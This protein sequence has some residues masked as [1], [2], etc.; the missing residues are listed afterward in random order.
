ML[1]DLV[2]YAIDTYGLLYT[3]VLSIWISLFLIFI[4]LYF[5]TRRFEKECKIGKAEVVGIDTYETD[6]GLRHKLIVEL[7]DIGDGVH[8]S[9]QLPYYSKEN[10]V[11]KIIEVAYV[12]NLSGYSIYDSR[13]KGKGSL[14]FVFFFQLI[15]FIALVVLN[16]CP[17]LF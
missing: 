4:Y 14:Q 7:L 15:F 3:I 6:H 9:T 13:D 2:I 16:V 11:G 5:K 8:Y 17:K 12:K 10:P 1:E